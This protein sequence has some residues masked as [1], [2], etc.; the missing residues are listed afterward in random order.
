MM[1]CSKK[2]IRMETHQPPESTPRSG[3][4]K[5]PPVPVN[6]FLKSVVDNGLLEADELKYLVANLP[7][8]PRLDA[9]SL[10][11]EL[12]RRGKLTRF[13]ATHLLQGNAQGLSLGSYAL[14]DQLGAGGMGIVYKAKHR[15]MDRIV[16]LKVL[17]PE[18]TR[19]PT[20]VR[21]FRREAEASARLTHPN[22][23][24]AYDADE[25][26]GVHFLVM[27]YIEGT[28]L[29]SL[30]KRQ[31]PLPIDQ[32]IECVRQA[33]C[34]LAHAHASGI[35]HRDIK[36][37]NLMLCRPGSQGAGLGGAVKILD[38][39]LARFERPAGQQ[40]AI[41][42]LTRLGVALGS[43][44]FMAPEQAIDTS[45]AEPRSDIYS[46][47]CTLYYLLTGQ[48]LYRGTNAMEVLTAH[49]DSPVPS[50][51]KARPGV[52]PA[53]EAIF[54]RMVAK[55]P[56]ERYA[57][58]R[59]LLADL[60]P[61]AQASAPARPVPAAI[62]APPS[63]PQRPAVFPIEPTEPPRRRRRR[64]SAVLWLVGIG[65]ALV[66]GF[67][68]LNG[69]RSPEPTKVASVRA[70]IP[71]ATRRT[72]PA[73]T[74]GRP[75]TPA[76]V[77]TTV[78]ATMPATTPATT[79]TK[80][81]KLAP[82]PVESWQSSAVPT[83]GV[84][85]GFEFDG[86]K[87]TIRSSGLDIW[88]MN[89]SFYFIHQPLD[90]DG[91]I[92]ARITSLQR[93]NEWAKAGLMIRESLRPDAPN[94]AVVFSP[95]GKGIVFLQARPA[96]GQ[97]TVETKGPELPVPCWLKLV[98]R[99]NQITGYASADGRTYLQIASYVVPMAKKVQVG[100]AVTSRAENTV[101]TATITDVAIGQ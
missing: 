26:N 60:E 28:D 90:G 35:V 74:T 84:E 4:G 45:R 52:P 64:R 33:A 22:I 10:A 53:L 23:V 43:C 32:A 92:V 41:N 18:I 68:L 2:A 76:T 36:P 6:V 91:I 69:S 100:L 97:A 62:K 67:V 99:G 50:L 47:G 29:G 65:A 93:T 9:A 75:T 46:L 58:I 16:A 72:N 38:M 51:A 59:A 98:R 11:G 54:Q 70:P 56:A 42:P 1:G 94:A 27:E 14:I 20:A 78:P 82:P 66:L 17:S 15:L 48:P 13:Q 63:P 85:A 80:P 83:G 19:N 25:A 86:E 31:G 101:T 88:E 81:E 7:S 44:E 12:V 79:P 21:R 37:G 8:A 3:P 77:P 57:S 89:D 55:K 61:L 34:G 5:T 73:P 96:A 39:G 95:H 71:S 40:T 24:A 87:F 30:V 49:L